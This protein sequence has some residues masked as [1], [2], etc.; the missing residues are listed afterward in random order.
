MERL[1]INGRLKNFMQD[2]QYIKPNTAYKKLSKYEDI[3]TPQELAELKAENEQL[4]AKIEKTRQANEPSFE[5][6]RELNI[7]TSLIPLDRLKEI[8]AKERAEAR[9][10][11]ETDNA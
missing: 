2:N 11:K 9:L 10:N 6:L 7:I 5:R 8:C 1:T 4:K 3:G